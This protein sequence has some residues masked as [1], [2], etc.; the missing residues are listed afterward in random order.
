MER[1]IISGRSWASL[2]DIQVLRR[3]KARDPHESS[4]RGD[5]VRRNLQVGLGGPCLPK[6]NHRRGSSRCQL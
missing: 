5:E 2:G 1:V 3:V 4:S 6:V